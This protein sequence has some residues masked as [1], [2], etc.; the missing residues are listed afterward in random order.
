MRRS[1]CAAAAETPRAR[2]ARADRRQV[3]RIKARTGAATAAVVADACTRTERRATVLRRPEAATGALATPRAALSAPAAPRSCARGAAAAALRAAAGCTHAV[4][5][6]REL[7]AALRAAGA[8]AIDALRAAMA[9]RRTGAGERARG[10]RRAPRSPRAESLSWRRAGCCGR[11]RPHAQRASAPASAAAAARG[12]AC[13]GQRCSPRRCLHTPPLRVRSEAMKLGCAPPHSARFPRS[14]VGGT[15]VT[16]RRACAG[17]GVPGAER[18]AHEQLGGACLRVALLVQLPPH[19]KHAVYV[20]HR[21]AAGHPGLQ[22]H[23]HARRR[24]GTPLPR[25]RNPMRCGARACCAR[26]ARLA[27][28]ARRGAA[29]GAAA[30]CVAALPLPWQLR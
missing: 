27:R 30:A 12:A 1:R 11:D 19:S 7:R 9:A 3:A 23:T 18:G 4:V 22:H 29:D 25:M 5:A 17:R 21:E 14:G 8:K 28:P 24:H 2:R 16:L 20:P 13:G 6:P 15:R 10:S 26:A